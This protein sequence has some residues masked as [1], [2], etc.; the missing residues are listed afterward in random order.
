MPYSGAGGGGGSAIRGGGG[1]TVSNYLPLP[2]DKDLLR[3]SRKIDL[4]HTCPKIEIRV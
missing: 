2:F 1:G 4:R 3:Y